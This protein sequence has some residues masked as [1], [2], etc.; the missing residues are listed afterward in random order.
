MKLRGVLNGRADHAEAAADGGSALTELERRRGVVGAACLPELQP[1][2]RA[3]DVARDQQWHHPGV[4]T[5][6]TKA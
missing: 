2:I 3:A 6:S 5:S 4:C 1:A